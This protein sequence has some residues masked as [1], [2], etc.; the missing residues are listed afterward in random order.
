MPSLSIEK[1]QNPKSAAPKKR[2]A[3]SSAR[4]RHKATSATVIA[5]KPPRSVVSK[6]E[7]AA[8]AKMPAKAGEPRLER[9]TK[10]ERMLS[11]L[12]NPMELASQR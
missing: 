4:R 8:A 10:Q 11:L 6:T 9:V 1:S 12:A 3:K 2:T 7:R 5:K